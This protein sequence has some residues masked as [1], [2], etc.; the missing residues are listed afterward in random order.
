MQNI[1]NIPERGKK[2]TISNS[3]YEAFTTLLKIRQ[4]YENEELDSNS[5]TLVDNTS[6]FYI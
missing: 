3:F 2:G 1:E 4:K 6:A 5:F